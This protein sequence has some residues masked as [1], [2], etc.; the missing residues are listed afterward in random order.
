MQKSYPI[1]TI[2]IT[3]FLIRGARKEYE[4]VQV[5]QKSVPIP[6]AAAAAEICS[7][8][9]A[10]YKPSLG[11]RS[12]MKR[13]LP[14]ITVILVFTIAGFSQKGAA[15]KVD[16]TDAVHAAFDRLLEGIRQVDVDK[17][18]SVY[19]KSPRL[20]IFNNNGTATQGWDNV[21]SNLVASYPKIKNVTLDIT[22][23]RIELLDP[24]AAY[25]SCKWKQTQEFEGKLEDSSGRMTL[26]FRRIGKEW[27]V[28]HRHTSPDNPGESR[29][30]FHS[31][32]QGNG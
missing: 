16:P 7:A 19:E 20:L 18:M 10:D 9:F 1:S 8:P 14:V 29:P 15:A 25:V 21:R 22:G 13:I 32:R 11:E 4:M 23:L 28:V 3:C 2:K 12:N 30:V 24:S 26:V 27:K 17:V 31:E 6:C 5:K